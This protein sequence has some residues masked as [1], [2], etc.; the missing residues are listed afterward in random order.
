PP[1]MFSQGSCN[2]GAVASSAT[3]GYMIYGYNFDNRI[4]RGEIRFSLKGNHLPDKDTIIL[5]GGTANRAS[6][7]H[8]KHRS[9]N[10]VME[11]DVMGKIIFTER[12]AS[13]LTGI[14]EFDAYHVIYDGNGGREVTDNIIEI[15]N[16]K[17]SV[18]PAKQ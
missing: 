2:M 11:G 16:G 3:V 13:K 4:A 14:F 1:D 18:I 7:I 8:F 5:H 12:T 17:V 10:F 6:L 9:N 15:R